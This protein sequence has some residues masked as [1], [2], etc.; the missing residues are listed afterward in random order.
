MKNLLIFFP[1]LFIGCK[2]IEYVPVKEVHTEQIILRDTIVDIKL[3][4]YKDSISIKDTISYLENTY[5]YSNA[6]YSSGQLNHSLNIKDVEIP[7]K[8]VVQEK[9]IRDSIPYPIEIT[10]TKVEY[11]KDFF[12]WTGLIFLVFLFG[13]SVFKLARIFGN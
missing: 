10:K 5:A 7:V 11:R 2:S 13:F 12:W 3:I 4:P 8:I 9:I 1:L 6:S